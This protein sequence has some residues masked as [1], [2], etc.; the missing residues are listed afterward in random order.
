MSR[1][2]FPSLDWYSLYRMESRDPDTGGVT[3]QDVARAR[4][5]ADGVIGRLLVGQRVTL[6]DEDS[7]RGR[8]LHALVERQRQ[9]HLVDIGRVGGRLRWVSRQEDEQARQWLAS[10]RKIYARLQA[11]SRHW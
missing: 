8:Y 5:V 1:S 10:R 9:E 3:P 6:I 2:A 7:P 4:T 11:D